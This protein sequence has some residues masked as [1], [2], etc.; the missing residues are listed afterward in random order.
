MW[1]G[2]DGWR[3]DGMGTACDA[4]TW[5]EIG[6]DGMGSD[7]MAGKNWSRMDEAACG[8]S[9]LYFV[10]CSAGSQSIGQTALM[11]KCDQCAFIVVALSVP[12]ARPG[13]P[14]WRA[15]GPREAWTGPRIYLPGG[16][17]GM[18]KHQKTCFLLGKMTFSQK[19]PSFYLVFE[20]TGCLICR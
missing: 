3:R 17:W 5:D 1:S 16:L 10:A 4:V 19:N 18:K 7:R 20:H 9:P 14:A 11:L 13:L 2:W 12:R 6:R 15:R 8:F